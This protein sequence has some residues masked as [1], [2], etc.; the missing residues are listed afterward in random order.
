VRD[1]S[2]AFGL[3]S[4]NP[5]YLNNKPGLV[6][7]R[8]AAGILKF[9][10]LSKPAASYVN[11][12]L[13]L[14]DVSG[15]EGGSLKDIAIGCGL[16]FASKD[17]MQ[18]YKFNMSEG[19][20]KDPYNFVI[21]AVNDAYV[22]KGIIDQKIKNYNRIM[23]DIYNLPSNCLFEWHT[24]PFFL[25]SIISLIFTY[26][27]N[28]NVF[29]DRDIDKLAVIK[30]SVM[31]SGTPNYQA[32]NELFI[33]LSKLQTVLEFNNF[34]LNNSTYK[35][36]FISNAIGYKPYERSSIR[37]IVSEATTSNLLYN[38]L[39]TGGFTVNCIPEQYYTESVL[40]V[41]I[42][43]AYGSQLLTA[44]YPIGRPRSYAASEG[45]QPMLLGA[46]M[47]KNF[48][49]FKKYKL[50]KV[51]VTGTLEDCRCD[52]ILSKIISSGIISNLKSKFN[53]SM[54]RTAE[55]TCDTGLIRSEIVNGTITGTV[56]ELLCKVS[57]NHEMSIISKLKVVSAMYWFDSDAV[58]YPSLI[59][60]YITD[61]GLK[62]FS[63]KDNMVKDNRTYAWYPLYL[64][65]FISPLVLE[66]KKYKVL[67]DAGSQAYQKGIKEVINTFYGVLTSVF[68]KV[69]NVVVSDIITANIRCYA[70]MMSKALKLR[71]IV[72]DGGFFTPT[73][74]YYFKQLSK[75]SKKPG[76]TVL[77]DYNFMNKHISLET[78][79]LPGISCWTTFFQTN[80]SPFLALPQNINSIIKNHVATFW[81]VYSID[82]P[83][84]LELKLENTAIA[85]SHILK[86]HYM[87]K[88]WSPSTNAY[89]DI[90][91][92]IRGVRQS[93]IDQGY[94]VNP[95]YGLL[96]AML[97]REQRFIFDYYFVSTSLF[98]LSQYRQGIIL[99]KKSKL[100]ITTANYLPGEQITKVSEFRLNN[101]YCKIE[102]LKDYKT[103]TSRGKVKSQF[104]DLLDPKLKSSPVIFE[105]LFF[106]NEIK[107]VI[108][109]M[110]TTKDLRTLQKDKQQALP[111]IK[112]HYKLPNQNSILF[113]QAITG[114][115]KPAILD[116]SRPIDIDIDFEEIED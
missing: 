58:D 35:N 84:N 76:L 103:I 7:H 61:K 8:K 113:N 67:K 72:T 28:Y 48:K 105:Y 73:E 79:P 59:A 62:K 17:L 22:L 45:E 57:T 77:S 38:S 32:N 106:T 104:Y 71:I 15:L 19:F 63:L 88:R 39:R 10:L 109:I 66:R 102:T 31:T 83:V 27:L 92:K 96:L 40:D 18:N 37:C 21:Y 16:N 54:P 30:Q 99:D 91:K 107:V 89:T 20:C 87:F 111:I 25:G 80:Q 52:L 41:D 74:I 33:T 1:L 23:T 69:N 24:I 55:A 47:N 116:N 5:Y 29:G 60:T 98:T 108:Y 82:F 112:Q 100:N 75:K 46:F 110:N 90:L 56:W 12:S 85:A 97:N 42:E 6:S 95:I 14:K 11:Y 94:N 44:I 3:D 81:E 13:I 70:W 53:P 68:F 36:L 43:G 115:T 93:D 49:K 9:C 114:I 26:F 4:I 2:D 51:V 64:K 78:K 50:F 65:D 101:N 86:S 34:M